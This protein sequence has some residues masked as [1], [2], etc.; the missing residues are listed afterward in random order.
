MN[1]RK[2]SA[3]VAFLLLATVIFLMINLRQEGWKDV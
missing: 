3:G 2:T 1:I